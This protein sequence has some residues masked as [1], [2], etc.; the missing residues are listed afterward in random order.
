VQDNKFENLVYTAPLVTVMY[1][2]LQY[3]QVSGWTTEM[4]VSGSSVSGSTSLSLC[5]W[6]LPA[7]GL[8]LHRFLLL[9]YYIY[10]SAT[11]HFFVWSTGPRSWD[12][13]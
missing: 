13:L 11:N 5:F 6:T 3:L 9:P 2:A 7:W 4:D 1:M 12:C 10:N 8:C